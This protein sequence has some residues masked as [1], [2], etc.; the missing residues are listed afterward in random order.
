M[1]GTPYISDPLIH[2]NTELRY[3]REYKILRILYIET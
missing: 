3:W 2:L 1:G